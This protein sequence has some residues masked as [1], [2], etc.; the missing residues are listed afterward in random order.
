MNTPIPIDRNTMQQLSAHAEAELIGGHLSVALDV[1]SHIVESPVRSIWHEGTAAELTDIRENYTRLLHYMSQG[2]DDPMREKVYRRLVEKAHRLLLDIQRD[3]DLSTLDN[4]YTKT[5]HQMPDTSLEEKSGN[6]LFNH[7]WTSPQLSADAEQELRL[8]MAALGE[9]TV[10]HMLCAL[11]LALFHYFDVAKVRLL[12][13]QV[14]D[15][16]GKLSAC[17]LFGIAVAVHLHQKVL[18]LY[19]NLSRQ[20]AERCTSTEAMLEILTRIQYHV[21]MYRESEKMQRKMEQEILPTLLKMTRQRIKMGFEDMDIDLSDP[22]STPNISKQVRRKL[23]EGMFQMERLY[24]QGMDLN[25]QTFTSLKSF[26]FFREVGNWLAPYDPTQAELP[27]FEPINHL[28]LC[29]SD[30]YSVAFL[31]KH[32]SEEQRKQLTQMLENHDELFMMDENRIMDDCQN[33]VQ[34]FYRLLK[35]SPWNGL[36]TDV[37]SNMMLAENPF[38]GKTLR[39]HTQYLRKMSDM[40]LRNQHYDEAE[41]H[42]QWLAQR[43]GSESQLLLH[44]ALCMQGQGRYARAID[45]Y[46]QADMLGV[47]DQETLIYRMQYCY[48][49]MGRY[50]EQ[51]D[52]LLKLEGWHPDEP[53][54]LTEVGLCLMQMEHWSEA[55]KRFYKMEF[56]GQRV[57]PSMRSIAWCALRQGDIAQATTYYKRILKE[58][59]QEAR[60]E[61]Y[62]NAAHALWCSGNIREALPLYHEYTTRY[63]MANREAKDALSP[64]DQ[65]A[66]VLASLGKSD[67]DIA[68]MHDIIEGRIGGTGD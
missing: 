67:S 31:L 25:L 68:L 52:C 62:L 14:D 65:D 7:I 46:R 32:V 39:T 33:V 47:E 5:A 38:L 1:V 26:P 40:L 18:P 23:V 53:K 56:H 36:W 61:D 63:L 24:R 59:R 29:D 17:A 19:G 15:A 44:L 45:Y 34:K 11:T 37:F 49:Q 28:P 10:S 9:L 57:L 55:Q 35:R 21:S 6:E 58:H 3:Y 42:L 22:D 12:L 13:T 51:L 66:P 4:I 8:A 50:K 60:W 54:V 16:R 64:F 20:I 43:E 27:N 41:R 30:K 48:A 2:M